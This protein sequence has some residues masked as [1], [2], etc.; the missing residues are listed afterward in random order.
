VHFTLDLWTS[1][2]HRAF[3][4]VVG[5]WIS[6][7]GKLHGT[8][9][10]LRRFHGSHTGVNQAQHFWE[11]VKLYE[12]ET[13]VGYF[14]L[15]N[16]SNNDT[17]LTQ[18]GVYLAELGIEFNPTERRLRCFGHVINL[19]VKAFL[20]GLNTEVLEGLASR[21][22]TEGDGQEIIELMEW[23]REG[24]MGKL[25]NICVWICRT[26]Q[27]RDGFT[28]K[29]RS[30]GSIGSHATLPLVGSI[31]RWGGDYDSLK[32]AFLLKE[33]IQ[34]FVAAA[35]RNERGARNELNMDSA[36]LDELSLDEWDELQAIMEIL[37]PFKAW[38][39]KLQGKCTNGAI[40]DIFPAMDDLL[41]S[42]ENAKSQYSLSVEMHSEH[43]Q[44]SI[45][46]AWVVLNK[47][48]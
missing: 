33:P 23:R 6:G 18:V 45:D 28:N 38:T 25:R 4:G 42:L 9:L 29:V 35:V 47:Y 2:N 22:S 41:S 30:H 13:K 3:L 31:T 40:Y 46:I 27:R 24:P 12:L 39:L 21:N 34:E 16:A 44:T 15:D 43:L 7:D 26:L 20:W 32:R 14:T 1:P 5:H 48:V 17:T 10:G 19:V 37:E 8:L 36:K 11:V